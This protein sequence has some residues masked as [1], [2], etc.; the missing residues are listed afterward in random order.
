MPHSLI[1]LLGCL[2][3]GGYVAT[4]ARSTLSDP[5]A[6]RS[7][8]FSQLPKRLWSLK[9]LRYVAVVWIFLGFVV[10]PN[11]L[12]T[13]PFMAEYVGHKL[14]LG[15]ACFSLISTVLVVST[16]P[17]KKLNSENYS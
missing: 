16:T 13:L 10:M 1:Q 8:W 15:V 17:R 3:I 4:F 2:A 7:R 12:A 14:L 9:L 11:G 5:E 6:M